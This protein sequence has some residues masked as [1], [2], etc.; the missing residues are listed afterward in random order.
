MIRLA[1]TPPAGY[2]PADFN[3]YKDA[4]AFGIRLSVRRFKPAGFSGGA[5]TE[6]V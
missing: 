1:E 5:T 3:P 2:L 6:N 4:V